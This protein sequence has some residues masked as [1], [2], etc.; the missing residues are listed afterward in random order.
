MAEII[1]IYRTSYNIGEAG[2]RLVVPT[3]CLEAWF[4][5]FDNKF[6]RDPDFLLHAGD[7][8]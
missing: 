1:Q 8:F 7:K 5:K 4:V 2:D 6:K 3:N